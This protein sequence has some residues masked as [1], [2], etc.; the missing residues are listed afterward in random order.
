MDVHVE[1]GVGGHI[2]NATLAWVFDHPRNAGPLCSP[3]NRFKNAATESC[4]TNEGRRHTHR[5][6]GTEI[7]PA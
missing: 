4:A 6:D 2:D 5:P 1:S 7:Q 3:H